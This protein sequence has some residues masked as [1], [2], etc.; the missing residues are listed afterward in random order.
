MVPSVVVFV[1]P[2]DMDH[3][4]SKGRSMVVEDLQTIEMG[5]KRRP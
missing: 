2:K 1:V 4:S 3:W 5:K